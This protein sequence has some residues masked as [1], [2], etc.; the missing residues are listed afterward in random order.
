[1]QDNTKTEWLRER[2]GISLQFLIKRKKL[3]R[4]FLLRF[5]YLMGTYLNKCL[6]SPISLET[7]VILL[8]LDLLSSVV[9]VVNYK[10]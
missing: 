1:M 8:A 5:L 6:L 3:M 7:K 4:A 10:V 2:R 9:D